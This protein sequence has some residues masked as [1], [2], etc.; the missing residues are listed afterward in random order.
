MNF[1]A[2]LVESNT[3]MKWCR[4]DGQTIHVIAGLIDPASTTL[5][6][7]LLQCFLQASPTRL[8]IDVSSHAGA[9]NAS[10]FTL[11]PFISTLVGLLQSSTVTTITVG[12]LKSVPYAVSYLIQPLLGDITFD[13]AEH[14]DGS[15]PV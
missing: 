10:V 8:I 9:P 2:C 15:A 11:I 3:A 1:E 5:E 6:Q 12:P 13:T 14:L 7:E 4:C